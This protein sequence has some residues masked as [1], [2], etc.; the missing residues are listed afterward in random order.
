MTSDASF[1]DDQKTRLETFLDQA[2]D[3]GALTLYEA[4]G[5]L[6]AVAAAPDP[7]AQREWLPL[8]LGEAEFENEHQGKAIT[9]ALDNLRDWIEQTVR[10]G[11]SPLP[12]GCEPT[13][14][15]ADNIGGASPLGQ[16]SRGFT[17]GHRW[18]QN[19]WQD[20]VPDDLEAEYGAAVLAMGFFSSRDVAQACRDQA[21]AVES[22]DDMAGH[23]LKLLPQAY[24]VY[25]NL[26]QAIRQALDELGP[27][28]H[29]PGGGT[30]R[31][32]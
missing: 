17:F 14:E 18:L 6:F 30:G 10:A 2:G 4:A 31:P 12:A 21:E 3:E 15:P 26:G 28:R 25:F 1:D 16:W 8:V 7:P 9:G 20:R 29:P 32:H 13:P 23:M 5:F 19:A 27:A 24:E 22:V 11:G